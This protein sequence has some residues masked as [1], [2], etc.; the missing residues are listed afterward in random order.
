MFFSLKMHN[1]QLINNFENND[2]NQTTESDN[3]QDYFQRSVLL[4]G[5]LLTLIF[6]IK[7]QYFHWG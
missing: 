2:S 1:S 5:V 6:F 7:I 4:F 3:R